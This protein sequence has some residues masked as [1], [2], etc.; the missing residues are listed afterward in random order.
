M[1]E[2]FV[3][4]EFTF[5]HRAVI[6]KANRIIDRY[7][8][9][10]TLRQIYY[11]FVAGAFIKN[12]IQAYKRL[13]EILNAGRLAG[14]IDWDSMTD[15]TRELSRWTLHANTQASVDHA[16]RNYLEDIWI[17]QDIRVEVWIEK[18]ALIGVIGPACWRWR[19]PHFACRGNVSQSEMYEA[20]KRLQGYVRAGYKVLV[21]HLGDHDPSGWDMTRDNETRLR[22][23]M[24][25][26][27]EDME[28]RRIA[29]NMDQ[30]RLYN[31]P[32]NPVK[33]TDSKW[34]AYC[35]KFDT[36][37][38]WELDALSP[39]VID[40]L[41]EEHVAPVVNMPDWEWAMQHEAASRDLLK[42]AGEA[43]KHQLRH[44]ALR[45]A[46]IGDTRWLDRKGIIRDE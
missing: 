35:R 33:K 24:E 17:R 3:P 30:V 25:D 9:S 31:P 13:G 8:V 42:E 41:I 38:S 18:D 39:D 45:R 22:M 44:L 29:L 10:L 7:D 4:K 37:S 1:R 43:W 15:R 36:E 5:E 16:A 2:M 27:H 6:T 34:K 46:E 28:F 12:N 21:L 23:F 26:E 14:M 40:A 19:L 32:D 20:G 11:Q